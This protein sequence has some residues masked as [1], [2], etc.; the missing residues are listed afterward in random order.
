M[1]GELLNILS[2]NQSDQRGGA[3]AVAWN[4]FNEYT[5]RGHQSLLV[6]DYKFSDHPMVIKVDNP[7]HFNLWIR[8][9]RCIQSRIKKE[10]GHKKG[11]WKLQRILDWVANPAAKFRNKYGIEEFNFPG[12]RNVFKTISNGPDLIHTHNLHGD[13][14]DLHL[15][16]TLSQKF[17]VFLT[18]HDAWMLSGHCAHSFDCERWKIGCGSCPDLSIPKAIKYDNSA[19]NWK[20][21]RE[22]YRNSKLYISTPCQW[23]MDKVNASILSEACVESKVIPYG[24]D[25]SI[26]YPSASLISRQNLGIEQDATV[27]LFSA[28]GIKKNRWK[29]FVM[30]KKALEKIGSSSWSK[31]ILFLALGEQAPSEFFGQVELRFVP[32]RSERKC[33]AD[34]Y[35][36]ADIY[37]H[38]A[39]ADTFPNAVLEALSCGTPVLGTAVGGIPEQVK[40][41]DKFQNANMCNRYPE[42]E[43]TGMLSSSGDVESFVEML[44]FLIENDSIR[45]KMGVNAAKD[46]KIRFPI[47]RQ[48]SDYLDWYQSVLRN[49][50]E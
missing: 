15:L 41:F 2:I 3:A 48:V 19:L 12:S 7:L 18:L 26:F 8:W 28:N 17:P 20:R 43:A 34:F 14:F 38:A 1:S 9:I 24:I 23:L 50:T 25:H 45:K 31:K 27:L 36:A 16:S 37:L 40:G 42:D 10:H 21:K 5:Q 11:A 29:D 35:R 30:M 49:K 39:K 13:Y 6:V 47:E 33:V 46:A 32:Y 44:I 4:L 22:I